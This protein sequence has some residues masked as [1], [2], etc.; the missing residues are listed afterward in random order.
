VIVLLGLLVALAIAAGTRRAPPGAGSTPAARAEGVWPRATD[1][2]STGSSPKSPD[3][4]PAAAGGRTTIV[5]RL[6]ADHESCPGVTVAI[7]GE[8]VATYQA[9]F[10]RLVDEGD[11]QVELR[12]R[13]ATVAQWTRSLAAGEQWDL[14]EIAVPAHDVTFRGP[15]DRD[16]D[17]LIGAGIWAQG[18][19]LIADR[20]VTDMTSDGML[21]VSLA[22][23]E[24]IAIAVD[25]ATGERSLPMALPELD[26]VVEVRFAPTATLRCAPPSADL[27]LLVRSVDVPGLQ[28]QGAAGTFEVP[29]GRWAIEAWSASDASLVVDHVL[30]DAV[31]LAPGQSVDCDPSTFAGAGQVELTLR[32]DRVVEAAYFWIGEGLDARPASVTEMLASDGR[33]RGIRRD[34]ERIEGFTFHRVPWVSASVCVGVAKWQGDAAPVGDADVAITCVPVSRARPR[35]STR[36]E[37][38]LPP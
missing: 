37:L 25:R 24:R 12:I 10:G 30:S 35:D 23:H 16:V 20:R 18:R 6:A 27:V 19:E 31:S 38:A 33:W 36:V 15:R 1:T 5:G 29:P 4:P 17:L 3:P 34:A 2:P 28:L 32:S 8:T 14:G 21:T 13:D 9:S 22:C 26:G 11:H 7:D